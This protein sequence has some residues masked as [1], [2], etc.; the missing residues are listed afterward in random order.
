I[1][2]IFSMIK[3]IILRGQ[4][5]IW[6]KIGDL[7]FVKCNKLCLQRFVRITGFVMSYTGIIN[8]QVALF[9][10][11]SDAIHIYRSMSVQDKNNFS[12]IMRMLSFMP[13][14]IFA[15]IAGIQ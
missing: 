11:A 1:I 9:Q 2:H 13:V 4:K 3:K 5:T 14:I 6:L 7:K 12:E 10:T 15:Q 8:D